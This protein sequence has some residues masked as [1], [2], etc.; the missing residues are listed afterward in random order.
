MVFGYQGTI[1]NFLYAS[2][3][4]LLNTVKDVHLLKVCMGHACFFLYE[5]CKSLPIR[6]ADL[7]VTLRLILETS[8]PRL[9]LNILSICG[10]SAV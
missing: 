2:S 3:L 1:L 8:I 6:L 10:P 5:D 7:S 4:G 9:A